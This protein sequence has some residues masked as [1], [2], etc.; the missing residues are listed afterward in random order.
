LQIKTL[1]II[2]LFG[3]LD[4]VIE[5]PVAKDKKSASPALLILHGPNGIGKTTVLRMLDGMMRLDFNAF[6]KVPVDRAELEFTTGE[7][8]TVEWTKVSQ[9]RAI[10]VSF[11]GRKALLHADH[12]GGLRESDSQSVNEFRD[13]FYHATRRIQFEFID[14]ERL[15]RL[16]PQQQ[17]SETEPTIFYT[18]VGRRIRRRPKA[19]REPG[20]M[21]A[22]VLKF[23]LDAQVDHNFYFE[24]TEPS[25]VTRLIDGL[26]KDEQ[27][28]P[29]IKDVRRSLAQLQQK[30]ERL[31]R[32]GLGPDRRDYDQLTLFVNKVARWRD[33][34]KSRALTVIGAYVE[35][36][37]SRSLERELVGERLSTF[38]RVMA[39]FLSDKTVTIDPEDGLCIKDS[40]GTRLREQDLS[41]GEFHLLYLMVSA[42]V[43]QRS[44]TVLA[45]DEPEMSMHIAWQRRLIPALSE[46]ASRAA[47]LFILATHSPE[48]AASYPEA[49]VEMTAR[50]A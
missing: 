9:Q 39:D 34:R 8:L 29:L 26:E 44:G 49:L 12:P 1:R 35:V 10:R 22:R 41:S 37:E 45:I 38:E 13:A 27:S 7:K 2:G 5:F 17:E 42:L 48:I 46:C 3:R 33:E 28:V 24:S 31:T 43:T 25:L 11:E 16:S 23:I 47:P 14:I 6:R 18:E 21:A 15:N 19:P 40:S 50:T 20:P 36:L 32:F 30:S 4:H